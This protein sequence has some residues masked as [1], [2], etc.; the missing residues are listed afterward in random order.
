MIPLLFDD[1]TDH[2]PWWVTFGQPVKCRWLR[3]VILGDNRVKILSEMTGEV[4]IWLD[5]R[6]FKNYS[7]VSIT[8]QIRV[9]FRKVFPVASSQDSIWL[10]TAALGMIREI[11]DRLVNLG[12]I[13]GSY[14][15]WL[16]PLISNSLS[17]R[18]A[19]KASR[20]PV[21]SDPSRVHV[22]ALRLAQFLRPST[23]RSRVLASRVPMFF[24][25]SR[26]S[27]WVIN[28]EKTAFD[29]INLVFVHI[30]QGRGS[31]KGLRKVE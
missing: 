10:A 20:M 1:K 13:V 12:K 31:L 3:P 27:G 2:T 26:I 5:P 24:G 29:M 4:Y 14:C 21:F 7:E 6:W 23:M 18:D 22:H 8:L 16:W 9:R 19:C 25:K 28:K 30:S 15:P 17:P 11:L